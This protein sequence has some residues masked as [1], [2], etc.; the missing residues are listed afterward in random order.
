M[1][2]EEG[3][4][5]CHELIPSCMHAF[6]RI[7]LAAATDADVAASDNVVAIVICV[8]LYVCVCVCACVKCRERGG[9]TVS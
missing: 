2:G 4:P 8:C 6:L 9:A 1:G 5:I 3:L 7:F